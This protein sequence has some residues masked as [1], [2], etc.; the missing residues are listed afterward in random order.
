MKK[1]FTLLLALILPNCF[2]AQSVAINE[3]NLPTDPDFI[4]CYQQFLNNENYAEYW[5]MEWKYD[6]SKD[7]VIKELNESKNYI[8]SIKK[9]SY[10]VKLLELIIDSYLYNLDAIAWE[11]VEAY[12]KSL[13]KK[14]SKEYRT[15]WVLGKFYSGSKPILAYDEFQKAI[16]IRGGLEKVDEYAGQFWFDLAI[17][18]NMLNMRISAFKALNLIAKEYDVP[19]EELSLYNMVNPEELQT[20]IDGTYSKDVIW[21]VAKINEEYII[22]NTLI[23]STVPAKSGWGLR[24]YDY[25]KNNTIMIISPDDFVSAD[26]QNISCSMIL[27]ASTEKFAPPENAKKTTKVING[28]SMDF[29][30][31]ENPEKYNDNVRKGMKTEFVLFEVPYKEFG[32]A[33]SE[34]PVDPASQSVSAKDGNLTFFASNRQ[35]NRLE[36]T[37]YYMIILDSCNAIWKD[38]Q[39][40]FLKELSN[41]IFE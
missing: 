11:D 3:K 32:Y 20:K 38:S 9:P 12:G 6:K 13:E 25:S 8:S 24:V 10:D 36:T 34:K 2:F 7:L 5:Q 16:K 30:V 37:M 33:D 29:Y 35:L 1:F 18:Y 15:F 41:C 17:A 39:S 21:S 28:V 23:G 14:Y 26:K 22:K 31:T 27:E 40:W 4:A 19:I